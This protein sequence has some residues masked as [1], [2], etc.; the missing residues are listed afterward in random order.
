MRVLRAL[1]DRAGRALALLGRS[2]VHWTRVRATASRGRPRPLPSPRRPG[3][4][5]Y[6]LRRGAVLSSSL[7]A[8]A[9]AGYAGGLGDR[10]SWVRRAWG[11]GEFDEA[12]ERVCE[13]HVFDR[14]AV[15]FEQLRRADEVGEALGARDGDVEAVAGEEKAQSARDVFPARRSGGVED[16]ARFLSLKLV[17]GAD[18][19]RVG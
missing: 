1:V 12:A 7:W 8:C 2:V 11:V 10:F 18:R 3:V 6:V 9:S 5:R 17:D 16:D 4:V 14:L 15:D 19:D 13:P